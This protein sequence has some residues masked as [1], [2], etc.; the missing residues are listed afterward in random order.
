MELKAL[1]LKDIALVFGVSKETIYAYLRAGM[2]RMPGGKFDVTACIRWRVRY[3]VERAR[4]EIELRR[5][6]ELIRSGKLQCKVMK[7]RN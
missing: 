5:V 1:K 2:P 4:P 7:K 6:N 3:E